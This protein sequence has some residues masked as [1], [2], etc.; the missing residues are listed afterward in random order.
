MMKGAATEHDVLIVTD[1]Q[2]DFCPGGAL[3]VPEGDAIIPIGD[4]R[5]R[6]RLRN[7]CRP[8]SLARP[9]HRRFAGTGPRRDARRRR[10][11]GVTRS[12]L[13]FPTTKFPLPGLVPGIHVLSSR[14]VA[15][16]S[17]MAGTSP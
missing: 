16:K 17:W 4:R 2:R 15:R 7:R 5:P 12:G 1:P 10:R 11:I 6:S 14:A 9:R 8:Q 3:A 13:N